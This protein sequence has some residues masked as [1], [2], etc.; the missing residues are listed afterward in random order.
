MDK[1]YYVFAPSKN[2]VWLL[3]GTG[4]GTRDDVIDRFDHIGQA[5]SIADE[6]NSIKPPTLE[7]INAVLIFTKNYYGNV[8]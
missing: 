4:H 1:K 7:R 5:Q 3:Y 6:L 2:D 8:S